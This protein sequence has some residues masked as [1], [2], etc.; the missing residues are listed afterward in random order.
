MSDFLASAYAAFDV[1]CE[2]TNTRSYLSIE[3]AR[4]S[5][6]YFAC[7]APVDH[8]TDIEAEVGCVDIASW[9]RYHVK[10]S[11]LLPYLSLR[12]F[13]A[14]VLSVETFRADSSRDNLMPS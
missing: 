1:P 8:W 5:M 14:E 4:L 7:C 2:H 6:Q 3:M 13:R 12:Y 11:R 9:W 10:L